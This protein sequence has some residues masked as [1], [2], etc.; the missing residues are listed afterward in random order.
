M[1]VTVTQI[2]SKYATTYPLVEVNSSLGT[3]QAVW[4]G[5]RPEL[6]T[7]YVELGLEETLKWGEN[8][9]PTAENIYLIT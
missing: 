6:G 5:E 2:L 4:V 7:Y 8:I 1:L 3:F 9:E